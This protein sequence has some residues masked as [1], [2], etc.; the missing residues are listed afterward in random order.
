MRFVSLSFSSK[1][2]SSMLYKY[3]HRGRPV[4]GQNVHQLNPIASP[5]SSLLVFNLLLLLLSSLQV[6]VL[7]VF[8]LTLRAC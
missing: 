3:T 7:D 5:F 4:Q 6:L 8:P 1:Q 2:P